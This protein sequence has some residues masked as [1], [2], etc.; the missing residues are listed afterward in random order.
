MHLLQSGNDISAVKHWLG[1]ADVNTT[2]GYVEIDMKMKRK[3]LEACEPPQTK[4]AKALRQWAKTASIYKGSNSTRA[5]R[6]G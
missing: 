6:G 5:L 3:A 4:T 1:H 2:H